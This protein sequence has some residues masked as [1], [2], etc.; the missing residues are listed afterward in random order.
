MEI[1]A[2]TT[3]GWY[4]DRR[5]VIDGGMSETKEGRKVCGCLNR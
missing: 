3:R 2:G 1:L 5:S 4:A